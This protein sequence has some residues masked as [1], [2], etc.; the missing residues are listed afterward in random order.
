MVRTRSNDFAAAASSPRRSCR[1]PSSATAAGTGSRRV[2]ARRS[3]MA[4]PTSPRTAAARAAP[5]RASTRSGWSSSARAYSTS[6]SANVTADELEVAEERGHGR[7]VE[8]DPVR[9]RV[10]FSHRAQRAERVAAQLPN[11]R[12]PR[13]C[14][15]T[16]MPV[17][18]LLQRRGG[19]VVAP[20]LDVGVDHHRERV[21]VVGI[22]GVH[23]GTERER[24]AELVAREREE[25]APEP[26]LVQVGAHRVGAVERPLREVV[27]GRVGHL[28]RAPHVV[29]AQRLQ[30]AHV[31]RCVLHALFERTDGRARRCLRG[32]DRRSVLGDR[33]A[34]CEEHDASDGH[35]DDH[36]AHEPRDERHRH[37]TRRDRRA[38]RCRPALRRR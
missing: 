3:P 12:Q 10:G 19:V 8:R 22:A 21:G 38:R 25:G 32:D 5:T 27:V 16:G 17:E 33:T 15:E 35:P 7:A 2:R 4:R 9:G 11:V 26:G 37:A 13:V 29:V 31:V 28:R 30:G 24:L 34:R 18:Q 23:R 14:G 20:E 6:R 1:S 36:R